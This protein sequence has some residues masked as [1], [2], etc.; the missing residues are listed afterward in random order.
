MRSQ[1]GIP[2]ILFL[3]Q[4][5]GTVDRTQQRGVSWPPDDADR[6][7]ARRDRQTSTSRYS[8]LRPT[9]GL[10]ARRSRSICDKT[11]GEAAVPRRWL[12]QIL[13]GAAISRAMKSIPSHLIQDAFPVSGR[14]ASEMHDGVAGSWWDPRPTRIPAVGTDQGRLQAIKPASN[15]RERFA[16]LCL[17]QVRSSEIPSH[18]CDLHPSSVAWPERCRAAGQAKSGSRRS[19]VGMPHQTTQIEMQKK[20]VSGLQANAHAPGIVLNKRL[21]WVA[22]Q[23][24]SRV[25]YGTPGQG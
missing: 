4:A 8:H 21:I 2:G 11:L 13:H 14:D 22:P 9:F 20:R 15:W 18:D 7:Q 23:G 5:A 3:L 1:I 19:V 6:E 16:Y 24:L 17:Q 10:L 25:Q 12:Q